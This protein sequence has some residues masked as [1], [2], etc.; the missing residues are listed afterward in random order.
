MTI[1]QS[2]AE[3][4]ARKLTCAELVDRALT[5]AKEHADLNAFITVTETEARAEAEERDRELRDG[6]DRGPLHGIPIALKDLFYT[7][8][9]RT[10]GGSLL[11]K[12]FVPDYDARVVTRL[13]EAGAISIG[14]LNM[15]ELAFGITSLNPHYGAVKNPLD[16]ER[17]AGGSSG[18]SAAVIAAD[19]VSMTLGSD[20]GGSIRIPASY[21]GIVGFK[22]TYGIV[23]RRGVMPL[24][25]TLDHVGPLGACVEDC[26]LA[27]NAIADCKED[28]NLFALED[29]NGIRVGRPRNFFFEQVDEVVSSAVNRAIS[30]MQHAGAEIIETEIPDFHALNTV[31]H[32]I[33]MAEFAALHV[34]DKQRSQFGE[35]VWHLLQQG[36]MISAPEYIN[37]QRLRTVFRDEMARVWEKIDL[38]ATPTTPIVAPPAAAEMVEI[39][40][41]QEAVRPASTR[42]VRAINC[43]GTPAI[44]LPCGQSPEGLPIGLQLVSPAYTDARLLQI[45]KTLERLLQGQS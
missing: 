34:E 2:G 32:M 36:R 15:H 12:N 29:C 1:R 31:S 39:N 9:I 26:A 14:K 24:G 6:I 20:T 41:Q 33:L 27:M 25:F 5:R 4:R 43:L 40:G 35:D 18:G 30:T 3:L 17:L 16:P 22:P 23:S 10:T 19:I 45:A 7:R 28:Y 8:G 11:Y 42:L 38:L 21:C 13:R 44:S 37:A